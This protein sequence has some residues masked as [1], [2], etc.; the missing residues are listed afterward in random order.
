MNDD[1]IGSMMIGSLVQADR[2]MGQSSLA[3][4]NSQIIDHRSSIP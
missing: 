3:T 1:L 2:V 4:S